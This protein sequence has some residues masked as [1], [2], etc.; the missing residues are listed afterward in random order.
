MYK[1]SI[2]IV[3]FL[4]LAHSAFTQGQLSEKHRLKSAKKARQEAKLYSKKGYKT[5]EPDATIQ[6]MIQEY[7]ELSYSELARYQNF[8]KS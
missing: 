4:F 1:I 8:Y 7:Y 3:S 5:Y 2:I 6:E